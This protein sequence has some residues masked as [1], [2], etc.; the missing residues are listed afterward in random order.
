MVRLERERDDMT[1]TVQALRKEVAALRR[2]KPVPASAPLPD[3][4]D[5]LLV[6]C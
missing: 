2:A 1:S 4:G 5:D 3:G 6:D